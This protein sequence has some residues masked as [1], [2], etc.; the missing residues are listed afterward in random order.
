MLASRRGC[1]V[2]RAGARRT[3][4]VKY[5][6]PVGEGTPAKVDKRNATLV[7]LIEARERRND[8]ETR[9][10]KQ[11]NAGG[12]PRPQGRQQMERRVEMPE[13]VRW[14][15]EQTASWDRDATCA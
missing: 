1:H 4:L 12:T 2:C 15:V 9:R 3:A 10:S 13:Y 8:V 7:F 5:A 14:R 6:R 11:M